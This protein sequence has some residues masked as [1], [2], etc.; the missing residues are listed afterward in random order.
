MPNGDNG[1]DHQLRSFIER[2]E[3]LE[4]EKAAIAN[5]IKEVYAEAKGSGF[6]PKIMRDLVRERAKDQQT[7]REQE[8]IKD[9][10][11]KALGMLGDTPLGRAA[12]DAA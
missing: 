3:R 11:R 8:E 2:V 9:V 4:G 10:Y 5:D 1:A 12:I 7:V 6:D